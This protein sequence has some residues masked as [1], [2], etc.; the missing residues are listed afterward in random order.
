MS[1]PVAGWDA[2][3]EEVDRPDGTIVKRPGKT[4][5]IRRDTDAAT[6][7]IQMMTLDAQSIQKSAGVN[8]ENLGRQTNAVSGAAIEARQNQGAVGTTE[9]FDNL[10]YAIQVQGEK[11][12]SHVEQFYSDKK[13]IRLTGSRG[14][15]DWIRINQPETQPDGSVRWINDITASQADFVV[16]DKDYAGTLRQSLFESLNNL[17]TRLP[18]EV[19]L[20]LMTIAMD[21]S[22]LPNAD[23][24]ADAIRKVTGEKRENDPH[25]AEEDA[26]AQQQRQMLEMQHE[27]ALLALD[28]QRANVRKLYAEAARV[29]AESQSSPALLDELSRVRSRA[30]EQIDSLSA[31]LRDAH[32]QLAN[33]VAQIDAESKNRIDVARIEAD[34]KVRVAEISKASDA[35]IT[36]LAN[37]VNALSQYQP[38]ES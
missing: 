23:E 17:A 7:Q 26:Q 24:V 18:P 11:Q 29:E 1:M 21:F 35:A 28:E 32:V 20:R 15:I 27:Q 34:A 38:K 10:R 14:K 2:M 36:D 3:R 19:S 22:D 37:R 13:V 12:L 31:Q 30:A 16:A 6:G 5:E 4:L 25:S 9:P 8:N 33:R